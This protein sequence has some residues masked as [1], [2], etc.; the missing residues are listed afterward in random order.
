MSASNC[1]ILRKDECKTVLLF[2]RAGTKKNVGFAL[3][4]KAGELFL[5]LA[6]KLSARARGWGCPLC[7][8]PLPSL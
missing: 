5:E 7:K 2:W 4:Q 3:L 6:A 8:P 1:F